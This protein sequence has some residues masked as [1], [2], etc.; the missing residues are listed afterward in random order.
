FHGVIHDSETTPCT[1]YVQSDTITFH[2]PQDYTGQTYLIGQAI[3]RLRD[4]ATLTPMSEVHCDGVLDLGTSPQ[5]LASLE[6]GGVTEARVIAGATLEVGGKNLSTAFA[7]S[8]LAGNLFVK[9]G[10]GG[11]QLTGSN[12]FAVGLRVDDGT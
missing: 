12:S 3:L 6:N 7:G 11:L 8:V 4:Q 1:V 9:T 2:K 10:T 5:S